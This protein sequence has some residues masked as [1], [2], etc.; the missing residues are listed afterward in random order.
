[1]SF[2]APNSTFDQASVRRASAFGNSRESNRTT[3]D[4]VV[5]TLPDP[6]VVV[7]VVVVVV[8]TPVVLLAQAERASAV[9]RR[10]LSFSF[11]FSALL[12]P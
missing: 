8:V 9:T 3:S 7:V 10:P 2:T 12:A 1:V 4:E 11:I 6:L 5:V